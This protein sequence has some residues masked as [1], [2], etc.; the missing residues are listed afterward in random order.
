MFKNASILLLATIVCFN[1]LSFAES[2]YYL[3]TITT[4]S[5]ASNIKASDEEL[6]F[7]LNHESSLSPAIGIGIGY[8]I[9]EYYRA[10]FTFEYLKFDFSSQGASFSSEN[11][12]TLTT[13]T[14]VIKRSVF[15]KS[16]I[17]NEYIN[18]IEGSSFK[19]FVGTG[20]GIAQIKEKVNYSLSGISIGSEEKYTFPLLTENY[21]SKTKNKFVYSFMIGS[22]ITINHDLN[23]ELMYSWKNFGNIRHND[24][25][26]SAYK[27]HHFSIGTRFD[28]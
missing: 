27:G 12:D 22:S 18:L 14:K 25:A 5:K 15:G 16:L 9:N 11:E 28:L 23:I 8:Y 2:P 24:L 6:N 20:V 10:D 19:F 13:G 21:T 17:F 3:K 4:I 1:S 26:K 7:K